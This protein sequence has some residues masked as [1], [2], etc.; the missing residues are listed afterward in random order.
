MRENLSSLMEK[1]VERWTPRVPAKVQTMNRLRLDLPEVRRRLLPLLKEAGEARARLMMVERE[2][3]SLFKV[4]WALEAE[5]V[6][7]KVL[8]RFKAPSSEA[9][10][11]TL[12]VFTEKEEE[13]LELLKKEHG[14]K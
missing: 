7:V 2:L 4:K 14:I 11:T 3:L 13:L 10:K 5:E 1:M 12:R 6:D 9:K 8:P